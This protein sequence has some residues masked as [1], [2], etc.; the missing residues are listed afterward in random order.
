M[1]SVKNQALET[2]SYLKMS[3]KCQNPLSMSVTSHEKSYVLI[4]FLFPFFLYLLL[5]IFFGFFLDFFLGFCLSLFI[6]YVFKGIK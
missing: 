6:I 2:H 1:Q 5:F 3:P 4:W